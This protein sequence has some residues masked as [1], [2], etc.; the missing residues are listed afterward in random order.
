MAAVYEV[1]GLVEPPFNMSVG[2][3]YWQVCRADD[4]AQSARAACR[5]CF[6]FPFDDLRGEAIAKRLEI[7][8][9]LF[10]GCKISLSEID[11]E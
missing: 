2:F 4:F 3:V 8:D 9:A 1:R 7:P 5:R 11:D 6:A 10:S